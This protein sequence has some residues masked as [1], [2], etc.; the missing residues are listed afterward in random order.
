MQPDN[1]NRIVFGCIFFI[2]LACWYKRATNDVATMF[3]KDG[4]DI[5]A[6]K[7]APA[8]HIPFFENRPY[9]IREICDKYGVKSGSFRSYALNFGSTDNTERRRETIGDYTLPWLD[10]GGDKGH[11]MEDFDA[12]TPGAHIVGT[13]CS[14][15]AFAL[16]AYFCG[17]EQAQASPSAAFKG[18]SF[19][20]FVDVHRALATD[21]QHVTWM[22]QMGMGNNHRHGDAGLKAAGLSHTWLV[23]ALPDG[24]YM[25]LQSFIEQYTF[26][27]WIDLAKQRGEYTLTLKQLRHKIKLMEVLTDAVAWT[28]EVNAAYLELFNVDMDFETNFAI[29]E[30]W[31]P[32]DPLQ[33]AYWWICDWPTNT[34]ATAA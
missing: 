29:S 3:G 28:P 25:W 16:K 21:G 2:V 19:S 5:P 15:T 11:V 6:E 23:T 13:R 8:E 12:E 22:V 7:R 14:S 17:V 24:H 33:L 9:L 32:N 18:S 4:K 31:D 26:Q 34:N 10:A 30:R 1:Q 27:Q 20:K